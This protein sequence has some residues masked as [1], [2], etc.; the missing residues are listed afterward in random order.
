[1]D[2]DDIPVFEASSSSLVSASILHF[3][4]NFIASTTLGSTFFASRQTL[5]FPKELTVF[6]PPMSPKRIAT[7]VEMGYA[8]AVKIDA[9]PVTAESQPAE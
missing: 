2:G 9:A 7:E 3:S 1:M 4:I 5:Q 6:N 8:K